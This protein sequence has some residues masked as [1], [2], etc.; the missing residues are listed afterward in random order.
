MAAAPPS[1]RAVALTRSDCDI[2]DREALERA[3][4]RHRAVA[5][6]NAAAYTAVDRAE[7]ER[8]AAMRANAEAP[9]LLAEACTARGVRLLHVST[10]FVFDGRRSTPYPPQAATA[11][12]GI[13]GASKLAGEEAVLTGCDN[14]LV[15]RTGWVYGPVGHNFLLT[16]LR[17]HR[18]RDAL[19]VVDDQVGTPT[20]TAT[21]AQALWCAAV[22][23]DLRG[24]LHLS[25]AGVCSWYDFALAIGEEAQALGLLARAAAVRPIATSEYPTAAQRPPYSVLDKRETW[26]A[27]ELQPQHWRVALRTVLAT[28]KEASHG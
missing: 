2:T 16:M 25:D 12:L 7:E 18:E 21:L 26:A 11:P 8:D 3:L 28:L 23:G 19:A 14:S 4:D 22:R 6:I 17:L 5:V 9:G 10:D 24:I 20:S 13:Y 15:V 27:L 1:L